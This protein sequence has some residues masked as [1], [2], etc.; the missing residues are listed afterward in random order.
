MAA[1]ASGPPLPARL[2]VLLLEDQAEDRQL[3]TQE[4]K[5]SFPAA[6]VRAVATG[7]EF[8][9][10]LREFPPDI[11]LVDYLVPGYTGAQALEQAAIAAPGI[12]VIVVTGSLDE[13]TAAGVIKAG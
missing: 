5:R 4:V 1:T 9:R 3:V 11:I 10:A 2:Q 12:P 13:E 6:E 8:E 7:R